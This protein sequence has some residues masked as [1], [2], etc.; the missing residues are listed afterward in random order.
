M[1]LS[2]LQHRHWNQDEIDLILY[3]DILFYI[4]FIIYILYIFYI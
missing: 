4:Y 2:S 3:I 1:I